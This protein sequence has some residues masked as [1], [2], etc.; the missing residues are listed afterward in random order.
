MA[1]G[2]L[3]GAAGLLA[4]ASATAGWQVLALWWVVWVR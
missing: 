2:S 4:F 1:G 3:V